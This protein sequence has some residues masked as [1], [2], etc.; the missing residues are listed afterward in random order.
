MLKFANRYKYLIMGKGLV[1]YT[2]KINCQDCYKCIKV[3][4]VKSIKVSDFSASVI[5]NDCVYCGKCVNACPSGAKRYR[6]EGGDILDWAEQGLPMIACLAPSFISDFNDV[7]FSALLK[8]LYCL[9]FTGVSETALGADLVARK[10]NEYLLSSGTD[11]V[12]ATCCPTVVNYIKVYK[13]EYEKYLA[14]IVSPMIA[15]ARLLRG[16]GYIAEKLVFIGPCLSKKQES[17]LYE[18]EI[19]AVITFNEF[20]NLL[21]DQGVYFSDMEK[22]T[23][24]EGF[25]IGAS[26]RAGLFPV[27][28]GMISTMCKDVEPVDANYM[29]FSGM[30]QVM[31]V[32]SEM[33]SWKPSKRVFIELMACDGGCVKGPATSK[34]QGIAAKRNKLLT[35]YDIFKR[36]GLALPLPSV[37][38]DLSNEKYKIPYKINCTYSEQEIQ[39][40]LHSMGKLTKADELNCSGCGYDN[41]RAYA[42]AMLDGKAERE[43][44][45]SQM[46]KEAQNKASILLRKMPYGVVLTD[47]NLKVVDANEK[48][49]SMG[50]EELAMITEALG[51][52]AGADLRKIVPYHGYFSA[53]IANGAQTSEFDIREEGA[54]LR[55]S[56]ISIQPNKLLC[57]I[58]QNMDDSALMKEIISEK[59]EEVIRQNAESVQRIAYIL[60]ESA[61]FTESVLKSVINTPK[62]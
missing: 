56:I 34:E 38:V 21:D 59:I 17:D 36:S 11:K 44:C 1:I 24:P 33:S 25:V 29:C 4:P 3:C 50:G 45:I 28:S 32:C 23:L 61:S 22:V 19:D 37:D 57:G 48:F 47:E 15:H 27:D 51:G 13:P 60:G 31:E 53:V 14:P 16:C 49:I 41:C 52:L 35:E 62:K 6:Q 12:I 39:Q 30:N 26:D 5:K 46:R 54:N 55:L 20:R 40:M 7:E 2:E 18:D 58:V 8:S 10:T 9:G 42:I 43:M